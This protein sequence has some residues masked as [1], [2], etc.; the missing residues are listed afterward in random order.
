[1]SFYRVFIPDGAR[2]CQR[3]LSNVEEWTNIPVKD[4]PLTSEE[5]EQALTLTLMQVRE[6]GKISL[7]ALNPDNDDRIKQFTSLSSTSYLNLQ[8]HLSS[9][10]HRYL[11]P[12]LFR[13]RTGLSIHDMGMLSG[14]PDTTLSTKMESIRAEL[15][16]NFVPRNLGYRAITREQAREHLTPQSRAFFSLQ[17]ESSL[18]SIWDGTYIFIQKSTNNEFQRVTY[19]GQKK[20]PL[21]KPMMGVLPDGYILDII[22]KFPATSNDA[23][24]LRDLNSESSG[25]Q[26]FFQPGDCF[27]LDRGFRDV[28]Q[29]MRSRGYEAHH[30]AFLRRELANPRNT[31]QL[32]ARQANASR[33]ITKP[34]QVV[35][36][37]FGRIKMTFRM[38][39]HV[40][41]NKY[42]ENS[43][44]DLKICAAIINKYHQRFHYDRD[45][46]DLIIQSAN[47][48]SGLATCVW[49]FCGLVS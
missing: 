45:N 40:I 18:Q 19:S 35:E 24:I 10:L 31:T 48:E 36:R 3:H 30:P 14:I 34:R 38:F 17:N 12:Y 22:P 16:I 43:Q 33:K 5:Y 42:I 28:V 29:A 13:L 32:S 11:G 4:D 15:E 8:S 7:P 27:I 26:N 1:M 41:D 9:R 49:V 2:C 39:H 46:E 6:H 25:F 44:R 23:K 20:A 37:V 47:R 21:Y